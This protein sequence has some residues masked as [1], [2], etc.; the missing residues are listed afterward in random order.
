MTALERNSPLKQKNE[1]ITIR[2]VLN[3]S[4]HSGLYLLH[5][6]IKTNGSIFEGDALLQ[7]EAFLLECLPHKRKQKAK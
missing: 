5:G 2:F 6:K 3:D 4:I 1:D 7:M